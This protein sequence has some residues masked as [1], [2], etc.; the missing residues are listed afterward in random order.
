VWLFRHAE[1]VRPLAAV[2]VVLLVAFDLG[3]RTNVDAV[4]GDNVPALLDLKPRDRVACAPV[5]AISRR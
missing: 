2:D 3:D 5:V 1:S 4:G